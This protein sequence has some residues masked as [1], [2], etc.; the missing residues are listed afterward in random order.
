MFWITFIDEIE[1]S[2]DLSK[3]FK[4]WDTLELNEFYPERVIFDIEIRKL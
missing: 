4:I 1:T 3:L 2:L